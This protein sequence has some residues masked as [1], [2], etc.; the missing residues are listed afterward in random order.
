M[1]SMI[2]LM[3]IY[4]LGGLILIGL[5]IPLVLRRIPP[6]PIYGFRIQWTV[7]DPDSWYAVN[8]YAGKWLVFMG[9]FSIFSAIGLSL[10]PGISLLAYSLGCL[11]VFIVAFALA[12]VESIR[13]L[14]MM[15]NQK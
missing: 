6:N 2:I 12:L 14:R 7:N 8:A 10:V 9:V 3:A 4:I 13:F 1:E 15:D 11:A 5:A